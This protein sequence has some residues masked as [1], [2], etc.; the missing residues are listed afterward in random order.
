MT[1]S[2]LKR[3]PNT[4]KIQKNAIYLDEAQQNQK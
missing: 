4:W 3:A 2:I 1:A